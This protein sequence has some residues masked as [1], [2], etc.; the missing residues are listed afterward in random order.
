M[1]SALKILGRFLPA[2]FLPLTLS[3]QTAISTTEGVFDDQIKSVKF[4]LEELELSTPIIDLQTRTKLRLVFD[5]LNEDV[6]D[7]HYKIVFCNADWSISDLDALEYQTGFENDKIEDYEFSFNTLVNF[8]NYRVELPNDDIKWSKAGNYLLVIYEEDK[9]TE[10]VIV[11]R[12]MVVNQTMTVRPQIGRTSM[13]SKLRSHQEVDF[14]IDH[15]G[16]EIRN[17]HEEIKVVVMQNGRWDNA[18]TGLKPLFVREEKLVFD[19]QDRV[20]FPALKEFR[21]IDLR[22]KEMTNYKVLKVEQTTDEYDVYLRADRDRSALDYENYEDLN[23]KFFI[24]SFRNRNSDLES[25]Y[26]NVHFSLHTPFELQSGS[27]YIFGALTDYKIDEKYKLSFDKD[28]E[29]Y[30]I[31]LQLKQ[32]FYDYMYAVHSKSNPVPDLSLLEG[33]WHETDNNYQILVYH[34]PFGARYDELVSFGSFNSY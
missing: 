3:A 12:F 32:G 1:K 7:F 10:P 8:T 9:E 20:V 34:R 18:I 27:V 15:P 28:T 13:V 14:E 5:D 6:R 23:G 17:P 31:T 29:L 4:H 2:F 33:N 26:A 30:G 16:I 22:A 24:E 25:E 19:Y 11:R 21:N